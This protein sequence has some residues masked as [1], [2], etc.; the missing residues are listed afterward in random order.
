MGVRRGRGW[1]PQRLRP[2]TFAQ[3]RVTAPTLTEAAECIE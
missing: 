2:P 3:L 1:Q